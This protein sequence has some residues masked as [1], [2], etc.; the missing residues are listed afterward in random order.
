MMTVL[1]ASMSLI[2]I[3]AIVN[4]YFGYLLLRAKK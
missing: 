1:L 4:T 2:V 3:P